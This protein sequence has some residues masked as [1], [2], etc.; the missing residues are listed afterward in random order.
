[1]LQRM[2]VRE[3]ERLA[4]D[5]RRH[6]LELEEQR[7]RKVSTH[8]RMS[9]QSP[10][11]A[12]CCA[13]GVKRFAVERAWQL[14]RSNFAFSIM[15]LRSNCNN[16]SFNIDLLPQAILESTREQ[17]SL[18]MKELERRQVSS[19]RVTALVMSLGVMILVF[20]TGSVFRLKRRSTWL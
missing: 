8:N 20:S 6:Q 19:S 9:S 3:R 5:E 13:R 1:M 17:E 2:E 4:D 11:A 18:R 10:S 12:G 16:F 14:T 15:M 7:K